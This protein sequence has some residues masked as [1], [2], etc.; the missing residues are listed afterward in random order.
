MGQSATT[1]SCLT[2][3]RERKPWL[4]RCIALVRKHMPRSWF[5]SAGNGC[6]I[7]LGLD[8]GSA[9]EYLLTSASL[10]YLERGGFCADLLFSGQQPF[11]SKEKVMYSWQYSLA[12]VEQCPAL[13][14]IKG[15]VSTVRVHA[16]CCQESGVLGW[17][18]FHMWFLSPGSSWHKPGHNIWSLIKT[19]QNEQVGRC[20]PLFSEWN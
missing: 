6:L 1:Y 13:F 18:H 12:S 2:L 8:N 16:L 4:D 11:I 3:R 19:F 14:F 17:V 9:K 5:G 20:P 7:S 15:K 10:F